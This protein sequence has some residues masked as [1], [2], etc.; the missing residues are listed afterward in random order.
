MARLDGTRDA[1]S[2]VPVTS[3]ERGLR[4]AVLGPLVV[5]RDGVTVDPGRRGQ[6][7]LLIRLLLADGHAV[8]PETLCE[9]LWQGQPP[10]AA[11]PSLY[12]HVS[13]L[14]GV[15]EQRRRGPRDFEVL[16]TEPAGYALRVPPGGRDTV[17]FTEALTRARRELA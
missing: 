12:A 10:A 2:A 16:V 15:L 11:M 9:D 13:K 4:V 3:G 14:R 7:L 8:A 5:R 6:R 17:C 1:P